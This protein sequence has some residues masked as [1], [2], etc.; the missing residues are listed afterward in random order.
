MRI[1]LTCP[2]ELW[3]YELPRSG[4]PA[5]ELMLYNL[6]EKTIVS[7]EVTVILTDRDGEETQRVIYRAHDLDGRPATAFAVTV[8]VEEGVQAQGLEVMIDKVWF[9]GSSVWRRGKYALSEYT[10][11]TL[12]NS[13]SL[14]MLRYVAGSNA[15]GFPQ[16]QDGLWVCVCGRPNA[17]EERVC[18]RCHREREQVFVQFNREAIEKLAAQR[19]QQLS[20]KAKAA[21]EDASRLQLQREKEYDAKRRKRHRI[22]A[23]AGACVLCVGAAYG[24]VFHLWPYLRYRGAVGDMEAGRYDQARAVFADMG[25]YAEASANVNRCLYLAAEADLTD[26][27]DEA[28]LLAARDTFIALGAYED[29]PAL[30]Q[31]AD[32]LRANLLLSQGDT[33]T[34]AA[35]YTSLADYKDSAAQ[36]K[37]CAYRDA[38][39]LLDARA[40]GDAREAFLALGDYSDA[41]EQA[42]ECVYQ[43]A[44]DALATGDAASAIEQFGTIEGYRDA[45]DQRKAAYYLYGTH[46][47]SAGDMVAA[48]DAFLAAGDYEDALDQARVRLYAPAQAAYDDQDYQTAAALYGRILGYEDATDKYQECTLTLA[49][50]AMQDREYQLAQTLLATLPGSYENVLELRQECIYLPASNSLTAK[51]WQAAVD[52]FSQISTYKDSADKLTQARYGLAAQKAAEGDYAAAVTLYELLGS[53][54]DSES[55]LRT[56]RY[57]LGVACLEEGSLAEAEALFTL[58]GDYKDSEDKLLEIRFRLAQSV[59][60]AGDYATARAQ[61]AALSGY[62][63]ADE[64]TAACDYALAGAAAE[65]GRTLDAAAMYASLGDYEDAAEQARALYYTLGTQA[66]GSGQTLSA[67]RLFAKAS[68]YQDADALAESSF[69]AY[70]QEAAISAQ[71]AMDNGEYALAATLLGHMDLTELPEKYAG[72]D[73]MWQEACY[74]EA[75]ALY[76]AGKPYEALAYYRAIPDYRDVAQRLERT[77][78]LILGQWATSDGRIYTFREDST[79]I[80][81][82]ENL[83]FQADTYALSTGAT[84]D[85][86]VQTHSVSSINATSMTLKDTRTG[87]VQTLRLT[88]VAES[89]PLATATPAPTA[90]P[91]EAEASASDLPTPESDSFLVVDD[92]K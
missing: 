52:G 32:W 50:R 74:Q 39:A 46:L 14:E 58:L 89:E 70:Y 68:G 83:Y 38:K 80:L 18:A 65:A 8:P 71:D 48:G 49:Q 40:F 28:T 44:A 69:D 19:E 34:A 76:A 90:V 7:V 22:L 35:L 54:K 31:E 92:D 84:P 12:P 86:L 56:A 91:E 23:G 13:R 63:Q 42:R 60:D 24:A 81:N 33:A 11:N 2:A 73:E 88:K 59:Y 79:C 16:E 45:D 55:S 17:A 72:L 27:A 47:A 3:R 85:K 62:G 87:S 20:L 43:A 64:M 9:E 77:C 53:Y 78:Y 57:N 67:A 61:F 1:D 51:D 75:Q 66:L 26:E 5:C 37:E 36:L 25:D 21:R 4:Y 29:A 30:L 10:P 41:A 15:V 6:G 82:G